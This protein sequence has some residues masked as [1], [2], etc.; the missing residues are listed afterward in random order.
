[1]S[2]LIPLVLVL[3]VLGGGAAL[4]FY[5]YTAKESYAPLTTNGTAGAANQTPRNEMPQTGDEGADGAASET[6][7]DVTNAEVLHAEAEE[8]YQTVID[9]EQPLRVRR[10]AAIALAKHPAG[11]VFVERIVRNPSFVR[12]AE[13]EDDPEFMV[14][15][16][17]LIALF[18]N[19]RYD[20][21]KP[22]LVALTNWLD[23]QRTTRMLRNDWDA[24]PPEEETS[25]SRSSGSDSGSASGSGSGSSSGSEDEGE[26]DQPERR[27]RRTGMTSGVGGVRPRP[28]SVELREYAMMALERA[29]DARLRYNVEAWRMEI[30]RK[31]DN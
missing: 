13:T 24:A 15:M 27:E 17:V 31:M 28:N 20:T 30:N 23:D 12:E 7:G 5:A 29:L 1:M 18:M 3:L 14:D 4:A 11:A 9:R 6:G 2:K 16:N 10:P 26:R 22:V 8:L 25:S 19:I 21:T